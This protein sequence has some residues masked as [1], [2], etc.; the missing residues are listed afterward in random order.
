[1]RFFKIKK[2]FLQLESLINIIL[3]VIVFYDFL[4]KL[5]PKFFKIFFKRKISKKALH[6]FNFFLKQRKTKIYF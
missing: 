4:N 1:M 3:L 6:L 5:S 2:C